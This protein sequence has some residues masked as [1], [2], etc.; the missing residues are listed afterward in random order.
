MLTLAWEHRAVKEIIIRLNRQPEEWEK[1]FANYVS[2]KGLS[3]VV[4][5]LNAEEQE[6]M[7]ECCGT[8]LPHCNL[9]LQGS[10]DSYASASRVVWTIGLCHHTQL[11]FVF[12]VKMK[13]CHVGQAG[14]ELLASMIHLPQPPKVLKLQA[15]EYSGMITAHCSLN[16]RDSSNPPTSVSQVTGTTDAPHHI[17]LIF[18][19]LVERKRAPKVVKVWVS[20][21][22]PGQK[23]FLA[24]FQLMNINSMRNLKITTGNNYSNNYFRHQLKP[25]SNKIQGRPHSVT[26]AE[27]QWCHRSSLQPPTPGLKQSSCLSLLN[28]GSHYVT[29]AG[30]N[31]LA[32]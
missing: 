14:L 6:P 28:T 24:E 32:S 18:Y 2:D 4:I 16:L 30:L 19:Y 1:M 5:L 21:A 31:L 29:Q 23:L 8:I 3:S 20:A 13:F 22:T 11:I 15:L 17:W 7:L 12:L 26:Q 9:H 25:L 10:S 27:V